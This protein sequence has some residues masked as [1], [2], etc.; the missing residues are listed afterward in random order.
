MSDTQRPQRFCDVC[1]QTDDHPRHT[2]G[3]QVRH[4]DCCAA[5]GCEVCKVTEEAYGERRYQD[6]IDHLMTR[7]PETLIRHED[8]SIELVPLE[9]VSDG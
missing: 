6:L 7:P 3:T 2:L 9:E 4:M 5:E 8:G 1:K